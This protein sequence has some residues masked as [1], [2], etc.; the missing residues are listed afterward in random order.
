V[1]FGLRLVQDI[2]GHRRNLKAPTINTEEELEKRATWQVTSS[3]YYGIIDIPYVQDSSNVGCS[4]RDCPGT[5]SHCKSFRVRALN[6]STCGAYN[7]W[8]A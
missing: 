1:G 2:G 8:I 6:F 4:T 5:R 3:T 7:S